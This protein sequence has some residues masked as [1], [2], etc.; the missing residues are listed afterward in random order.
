MSLPSFL[1]YG[2]LTQAEITREHGLLHVTPLRKA[3]PQTSFVVE[4]DAGASRDETDTL[5]RVED[6]EHAEGRLEA[7]ASAQRD[8]EPVV[9][10]SGGSYQHEKMYIV[11][12]KPCRKMCRLAVPLYL[13]ACSRD[14]K[15]I[16][17]Q[18]ESN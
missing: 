4:R 17:R 12:D 16:C 7:F 2:V 6:D 5:G 10:R 1:T 9:A 8:M 15:A 3:I 11:I 14:S 18:P 13:H